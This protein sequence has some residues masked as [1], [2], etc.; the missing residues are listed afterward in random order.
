ML[1]GDIHTNWV[2]DLHVDDRDPTSPVVGTEFVGTSITSGGDG[3]D[4][5]PRYQAVLAENPC[6]KFHNAPARLRPLHGH[7]AS[8]GR[9]TTASCRS[10]RAP[11]PRSRRRASLV[12]EDGRPGVHRA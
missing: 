2:N 12:V 4:M 6:V 1:T 9:P 8:A 7:A 3:A 11:A 5:S 10:C